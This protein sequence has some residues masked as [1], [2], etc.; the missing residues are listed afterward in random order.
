MYD[1]TGNEEYLNFLDKDLFDKEE[2]DVRR[3]TLY[4][5]ILELCYNKENGMFFFTKF[6]L[7]PLTDIGFPKPFRFNKV[8]RKWERLV[9]SHKKLAIMAHR[10]LGKSIFFSEIINLY[11][12]FLFKHR[13]VILISASQD[14]ANHLIEEIKTIV[15]HNEWLITKKDRN[16]W[17]NS[18]IGYNDGY[19]IGVGIGGEILGQHVDRIVLDD[20]LRDDN[21]LTDLQIEDY[22]DMKLDPMLLNR[23]GQLIMVGTPKRST[24]FFTTILNRI[25]EEKDC[26]WKLFKF[27]AILDYEKKILLAPDRFTWDAIMN[28]RLSMGPL[29]FARE[30][31]LDFF[32]RDKS[33]FSE[34]VIKAAK[35]KGKEFSLLKK[36]ENLGPQ[37]MLVG[38]IDVAR[39]GAASADYTVVILLAYNSI[40]QERR[41]VYLWREKG[42]KLSEQA[43]IISEI[44]EKFDH[45]MF[46][47]EKNNIG[48][49]MID[50]LVDD[51]N[52]NVES[53]TTTF[54]SKE[55]IVR[56]LVT[57]F[58]YGKI[59]LPTADHLSR[60]IIEELEFE[61][62][63]FSVVKTPRGDETF[64]GLGGHDDQVMALAIANKAT[65]TFG[66][67]FAVTNFDGDSAGS[68]Y[69]GLVSGGHET[70]LVKKIRMGIIK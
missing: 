31:Q 23:D 25:S 34:D 53:F 11:D 19:I 38:G 7:G 13:R 26:P 30:Y 28:K 65:Q 3:A 52:V 16:K 48:Q 1:K 24:D 17:A 42:I 35:D 59:I 4:R 21:K 18:S 49:E 8:L 46:L 60:K 29:K 68:E 39:S 41:L 37:W 15:D 54:K 33:L 47:V 10:G 66:T 6:I 40:T 9:R 43:R 56:F 5:T 50:R 69:D 57:A 62:Q 70:D 63:K 45:P 64:R 36:F 58:E 44:S 22:V 55:E 12:M 61:L 27:P 2:L 14:Q 32:S 51:Y 20:I 67:P